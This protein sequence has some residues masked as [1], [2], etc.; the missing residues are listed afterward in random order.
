VDRSNALPTDPSRAPN[1]SASG[2]NPDRNA[3]TTAGGSRSDSP[4]ARGDRGTASGA[5]SGSGGG[6][7]SATLATQT[8]RG[9]GG[10]SGRSLSNA[11]A[12][13][14]A[15]APSSTQSA[16]Q[17]DEAAWTRAQAAIA[18]ERIPADLRQLVQD[19]F[20]AIRRARR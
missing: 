19:Y 10:V 4:S 13:E 9:A 12:G 17:M 7:R 3:T 15:G 18:R 16:A 6:G 5:Q 2:T 8:A 14:R 11:P 20:T 1:E